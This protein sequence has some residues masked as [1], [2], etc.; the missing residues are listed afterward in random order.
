MSES[1]SGTPM[2]SF[3]TWHGMCEGVGRDSGY[4]MR[5]HILCMIQII[6]CVKFKIVWN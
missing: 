2:T 5:G 3:H 4:V 6:P 1:L